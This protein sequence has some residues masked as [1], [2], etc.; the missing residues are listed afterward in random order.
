MWDLIASVPDNC[1]SFYFTVFIPAGLDALSAL[2][3]ELIEFRDPLSKKSDN[4][5]DNTILRIAQVS[6]F[7]Q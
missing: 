2:S 4:D 1:L 7:A 5:I 6:H 3:K